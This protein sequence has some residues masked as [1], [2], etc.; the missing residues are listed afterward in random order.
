MLPLQM[1]VLMLMMLG[2]GVDDD[3]KIIVSLRNARCVAWAD[4][5]SPI[6]GELFGTARLTPANAPDTQQMPPLP[7][8]PVAVA[9]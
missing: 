7:V 2:T 6:S 1:M 5:E 9:S 4:H 8:V 3:D